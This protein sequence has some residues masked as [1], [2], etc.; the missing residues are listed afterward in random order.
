MP[1][2]KQFAGSVVLLAALA[3]AVPASAQWVG[4]NR[5]TVR[6][7][8]PA[9]TGP[10]APGIDLT[11]YCQRRGYYAVRPENGTWVCV[12]ENGRLDI[13]LDAACRDM[14]GPSARARLV[15]GR[16]DTWVCYID[17]ARPA[18]MG[19]GAP[20][21][22]SP[23]NDAGTAPTAPAGEAATTPATPTA[24]AEPPPD[25]TTAPT[26]PPVFGVP[27]TN[28]PASP[29]ESAPS[30]SSAMLPTGPLSLWTGLPF[31]ARAV[32]AGLG[33]LVLGLLLGTLLRRKPDRE[34]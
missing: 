33:A 21:G 31:Y 7:A 22:A 28:S 16:V 17:A 20:P 19:E 14:F 25:G 6:R 4:G 27:P 32:I 11:G 2:V 34:D 29:V 10:I 3:V 30:D 15:R 23:G 9:P 8:E 12:N 26:A 5:S 24:P 13:D 1:R 18:D